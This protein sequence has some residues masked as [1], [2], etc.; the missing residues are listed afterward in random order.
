MPTKNRQKMTVGHFQGHK[1]NDS[2]IFGI[3]LLYHHRRPTIQSGTQ[4][5]FVLVLFFLMRQ[6]S[7]FMG[8]GNPK[9]YI[10]KVLCNYEI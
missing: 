5:R 3:N 6:A 1:A 10:N 7:R 4:N 2:V 9:P 8:L